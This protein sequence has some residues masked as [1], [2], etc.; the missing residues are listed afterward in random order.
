MTN[1]NPMHAE[2][3]ASLEHFIKLADQLRGNASMALFLINNPNKLL[4]RVAAKPDMPVDYR[5]GVA[6]VDVNL[7]SIREAIDILKDISLVWRGREAFID[8]RETT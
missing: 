5:V 4:F 7:E 8:D 1:R 2:I 6:C 3:N